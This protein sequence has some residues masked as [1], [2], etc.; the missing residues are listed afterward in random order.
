MKK[1]LIYLFLISSLP[2]FAQK[3][4]A[5]TPFAVIDSLYREDQFYLGFTYNSLLN[6]PV[7]YA[8]T[9][10]SLGVTAGFL[11]DFPVNESRTVA[12]A[13]GLGASYNKHHQNILVSNQNNQLNYQIISDQN[14]SRNKLEQV[15]IDIPFEVRWRNSTPTKYEFFRIYTGFKVGY[16]VFDKTKFVSESDPEKIINN[17]DFNRLQYG[18]TLSIGYNTWN[19]HAYYGLNNVFKTASIS[20]QNIQMSTLN[21]GLIFYIL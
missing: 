1:L 17:P 9:G 5:K 16:L 10:F 7:N 11:R 12:I 19:F 4:N 21:V 3:N 20:G 18:P 6:T 15:F 2:V 14:F 8:P 13:V